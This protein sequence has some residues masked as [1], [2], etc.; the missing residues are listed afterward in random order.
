MG[1][2]AAKTAQ[3]GSV[4]TGGRQGRNEYRAM[5]PHDY[6]LDLTPTVDQQSKLSVD[7]K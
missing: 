7:F 1:V 6:T 5:V 2:N 4:T 3:T